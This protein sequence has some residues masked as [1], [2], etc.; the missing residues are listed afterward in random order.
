MLVSSWSWCVFPSKRN[1]KHGVNQNSYISKKQ[2]WHLKPLSMFF[3]SMLQFKRSWDK[4]IFFFF[5]DQIS[6]SCTC[7]MDTFK[8]TEYNPICKIFLEVFLV[9]RIP[10]PTV[11]IHFCQREKAILWLLSSLTAWI[12]VVMINWLAQAKFLF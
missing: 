10:H 8:K 3:F 11:L 7:L 5:Y 2:S 1:Q 12:S 9:A 6:F 4:A